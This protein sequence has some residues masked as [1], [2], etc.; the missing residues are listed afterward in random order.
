MA[1]YPPKRLPRSRKST[2]AKPM[3]T[4]LPGRRPGK[5]YSDK[6]LLRA[7]YDEGYE[8]GKS[9]EPV[10]PEVRKLDPAYYNYWY[11][12]WIDGNHEYIKKLP[13]ECREAER[14]R[15]REEEKRLR[16]SYASSE[17]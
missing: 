16:E 17:I 6:K 2:F 4:T 7:C 12:G 11:N 10:V 14:N 3:H 1:N 9:G 8:Y 13:D 15:I 5:S